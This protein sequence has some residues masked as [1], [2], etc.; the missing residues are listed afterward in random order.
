MNR[1]FSRRGG[2][3]GNRRGITRRN[4]SLRRIARAAMRGPLMQSNI[5]AQTIRINR[6]DIPDHSQRP[7]VQRVVRVL[8]QLNNTSQV[9]NISPATITNTDQADYGT[10]SIRYLHFRMVKF[11]L[12]ARPAD[13]NNGM[14]NMQL[15]DNNGFIATT[16]YTPG[17]GIASIGIEMNLL[18]KTTI[19]LSNAAAQIL[20]IKTDTIIGTGDEI[21]CILDCHVIFS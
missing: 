11:I 4:A 9:R 5:N 17:V 7:T 3:F 16:S 15:I 10:A 13:T 20:S 1:N 14:Y 18:D 8:F 12:Y 19:Y 2:R 21:E 6:D